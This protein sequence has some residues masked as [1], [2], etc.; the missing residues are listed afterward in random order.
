MILPGVNV[1]ELFPGLRW[2]PPLTPEKSP[3]KP[4]GLPNHEAQAGKSG[5]SL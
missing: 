2:R 3:D 4:S 1:Q 5:V